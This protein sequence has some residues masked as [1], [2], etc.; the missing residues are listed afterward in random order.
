MALLPALALLFVWRGEAAAAFWCAAA[1]IL[2]NLTVFYG[3]DITHHVYRT[4]ALADQVRHGRLDPLLP[5]PS[6][7]ET[8]PVFVYYSALPYLPTVL[9]SLAGLPA[10][11]AV[12]AALAAQL[13]IMVVGMRRLIETASPTPKGREIGY[14]AAIVFLCA[15]YVYGLWLIRMALAETWVYCIVPWV[16]SALLRDKP[17]RSVTILLFLQ[18]AAHPIVFV[19]ATAASLLAACGLSKEN[20]FAVTVRLMAPAAL[21]LIAAMPFWL[22]Q[23]LWKGDILGAAGLPAT[24]GDSFFTAAQLADPRYVRSIGL[25]LPLAVGI[26]VVTAGLGLPARTWIPVAAFVIGFAVQTRLLRPLTMHLPILSYSL[27]VWRLMLPVAFLGFGALLS[28]WAQS[29]GGRWLL[30]P[31]AP[32]SLLVM[33]GYLLGPAQTNLARFLEPQSDESWYRR[34]TEHPV[35]WGRGEFLP[36]YTSLPVACSVSARET[37]RVTFADL[38]AGIRPTQPY[39]VVRQAPVGFVDYTMDGISLPASACRTDLIL[40]PL[41]PNTVVQA[42]TAKVTAVMWLRGTSLLL[43]LALSATSG[44]WRT[45][46]R[47]HPS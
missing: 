29:A 43:V 5:N 12:K 4:L 1:I 14:L 39:L 30:A 24:F 3:E 15:N 20:P 2:A 34:Y 25:L 35:S 33:I 16:A 26:M 44:L 23:F 9:L 10:H 17:G 42:S 47:R 32:L 11:A 13:F 46:A 21:A 28:G 22:P 8:L 40:G 7:G 45:A 36:N 19:Q 27:F 31:L 41:Q 38:R 37:Q 6:T 18:A